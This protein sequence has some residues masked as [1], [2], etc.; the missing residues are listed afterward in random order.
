MDGL[1]D[2]ALHFAGLA[3]RGACVLLRVGYQLLQIT[4]RNA[5]LS[6][7]D[8]PD[9]DALDSAFRKL[10]VEGRLEVEELIVL[11]LLL[12][13][14]RQISGAYEEA[15]PSVHFVSVRPPEAL[16]PQGPSSNVHHRDHDKELLARPLNR[17]VGSGREKGAIPLALTDPSQFRFDLE[18]RA[19]SQI[20]VQGPAKS[21]ARKNGS[22]HGQK[23]R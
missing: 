19:I 10:L 8:I 21:D 12:Q 9:V 2:F 1:G 11:L 6:T 18:F 14:L 17:Y 4:S 22:P 13:I 16:P 7:R 20:P 5:P 23:L 15:L 3:V